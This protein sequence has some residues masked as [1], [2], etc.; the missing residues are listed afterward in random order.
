MT[1]RSFGSEHSSHGDS[2]THT[3]K[4]YTL[5]RQAVCGNIKF[6]AAKGESEPRPG[7]RLVCAHAQVAARACAELSTLTEDLGGSETPQPGNRIQCC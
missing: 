3:G 4:C 5:A 7:H 6:E 1:T 2:C